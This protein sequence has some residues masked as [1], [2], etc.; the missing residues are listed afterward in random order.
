MRRS[1]D[2][3][4]PSAIWSGSFKTYS[5]RTSRKTRCGNQFYTEMHKRCVQT[6]N[7]RQFETTKSS[8]T[9]TGVWYLTHER[10][11][12]PWCFRRPRL[13]VQ[14]VLKF[15]GYLYSSLITEEHCHVNGSGAIACSLAIVLKEYR[16]LLFL[17]LAIIDLFATHSHGRNVC[18]LRVARCIR[19]SSGWKKCALCERQNSSN[20]TKHREKHWS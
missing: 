8:R 15:H 12:E 10:L 20:F 13:F 18:P 1:C 7:C 6:C 16:A 5:W 11:S 19:R 14:E 3:K 2:Y 17:V 4:K 9:I